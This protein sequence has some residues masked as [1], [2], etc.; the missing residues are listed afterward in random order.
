[1]KELYI[2]R[3][4]QAT[5][6]QPAAPLTTLGQ[7][8]AQ[9]VAAQLCTL[10]L[11]YIVSSPYVRALQTIEPLALQLGLP[12]HTDERLIERVLC[13]TDEPDWRAMLRRTYDDMELCYTGGESSRQA[14]ER[15]SAVV[16]QFKAS[17]HRC[18]ALVSHGNLISLLLRMYDGRIGF[19]EWEQLTNPDMYYIRL[20][21]EPP[22]IKRVPV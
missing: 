7:V 10:P 9:H 4:C 11:D 14:T 6:Q 19:T 18:A 15:V 17:D 1:M 8:Q 12:I 20:D 2:I 16:E 13:H 5:G 3:H 22:V 21:A